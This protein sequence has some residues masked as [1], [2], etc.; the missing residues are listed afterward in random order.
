MSLQPELI[1]CDAGRAMG[2]STFCCKLIVRYDPDERPDSEYPH[3]KKNCVDKDPD[4]GFCLHLD[5][6]SFRCEIWD[7][8]PKVCAQYGCNT[9]PLLQIVLKQ[10]FTSLT[11]LLYGSCETDRKNWTLIPT[12]NK[13]DDLN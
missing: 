11:N 10:G 8:R 7:K 3:I 5:K 9:D 13:S 1:D 6:A 12:L 2:C 4:D